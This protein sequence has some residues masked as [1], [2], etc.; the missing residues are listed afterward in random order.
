M[1]K[2]TLQNNQLNF[3]RQAVT[4]ETAGSSKVPILKCLICKTYEGYQPLLA[5][6]FLFQKC[7]GG[8]VNIYKKKIGCR[9]MHLNIMCECNEIIAFISGDKLVLYQFI[10]I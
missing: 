1:S 5:L 4:A 6:L 7:A 3:G 2:S 8:S 10:L 9:E